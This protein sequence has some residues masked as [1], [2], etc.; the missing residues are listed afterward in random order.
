MKTLNTERIVRMVLQTTGYI[1]LSD[2]QTEF[3]GQNPIFLSEY[4]SNSTSN[5]TTGVIGIPT[6]GN[7]ISLSQFYG[8]SNAVTPSSGSLS[9][10][11]AYYN[12]SSSYILYSTYGNGDVSLKTLANISTTTTIRTYSALTKGWTLIHDK[13]LDSNVYYSMP[14][15][16]RVLYKYVFAKG[17]NTFTSTSLYTLSA[18]TTSV[19]GSCYAPIAMGAQYGA[20]IIGGFSQAVLHV[21]EFNATKTG[22]SHAYTVPYTSEVYGTEVIPKVASGFSKNFGVAYTRASRQMSSWVVDLATRSWTNRYD[23]SYSAGTT[24]PSNGCGMIFYPIGKP[25]IAN[26]TDTSTNRIAMNDTSSAFL[27]VWSIVE[28]GNQL[29]FTFKSKIPIVS[30]SGYP[31]HLSQ[32]AYDAI[33]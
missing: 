6:T 13:D 19:L 21:M 33:S 7:M 20:F 27:Y 18:A 14:E 12:S 17:A 10:A 29:S 8:T 23:I 24:G 31:Y 11:P 26:D 3:G 2:I 22:I 25:I 28:N 5:Y 30:N 32:T 16:T 15:G 1:L 9:N 4:Y